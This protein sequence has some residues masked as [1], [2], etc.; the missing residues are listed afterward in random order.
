MLEK[1]VRIFYEKNREKYADSIIQAEKDQA[2]TKNWNITVGRK[3]V[4][5]LYCIC[6]N[7]YEIIDHITKEC[8]CY[9][10]ARFGMSKKAER[11]RVGVYQIS[12]RSEARAK[13]NGHRYGG[14]SV[15]HVLYSW[16]CMPTEEN[17]KW[18]K[19]INKWKTAFVSN[20]R[21]K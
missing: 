5:P 8:P 7:V 18:R 19:E 6:N 14:Q 10:K 21:A 15:T 16:C 4:S 9:G 3:H 2:L 1:Y 20:R 12:D 13:Q 11:D 17:I